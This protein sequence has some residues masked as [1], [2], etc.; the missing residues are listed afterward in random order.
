M[1]IFYWEKAFHAGK[2][3]EKMTLPPQKTFPVMPL[4]Q[5]FVQVD[6]IL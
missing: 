2:K 6:Q 4:G 1:E 3:T 5:S